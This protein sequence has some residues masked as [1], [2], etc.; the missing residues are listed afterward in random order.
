MISTIWIGFAVSIIICELVGISGS[1]FTI[2]SIPTWYAKLNKPA[3]S[4]PNWIFGPVWTLLYAMQGIAAYL[5]YQ[6]IFGSPLAKI[7]FVLFVI[8]LILNAIWTPLFFGLK[9]PRLAFF[10]ILL[11]WIFIVLS[12]VWF[13]R[14]SPTA[15]YLMLPYL[16]WVS[17]ASAL[18]YSIWRLN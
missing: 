17:F 5:I 15:G 9:N 13:F 2:K 6:K 16:A 11:M 18:N 4:P 14:V 7:A 3:F 10:E 8:Q 1:F 12:T